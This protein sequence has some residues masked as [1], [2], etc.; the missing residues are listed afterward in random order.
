M[1]KLKVSLIHFLLSLGTFSILTMIILYIW[2]PCPYFSAAGGW[3]G[4]KIVS[5]VDVVLGP[6]LTFILYSNNKPKKELITDLSIVILLQLSAMA[7]GVNTIYMQRPVAIVYWEKNFITV[8]ASV[9]VQQNLDID[10]L[11]KF[12]KSLPVLIYAQKPTK[13]E[14]LQKMLDLMNEN[15][16][17]PHHQFT[18]YRPLDE[19]FQNMKAEQL[20]ID[21]VISNN[22][23]I[24]AQLVNKLAEKGMTIDN[25]LYFPLRSK[26]KN[27]ILMINH[28]GNIEDFILVDM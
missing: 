25:I 24:K 20:D 6:L 12:G 16:V 14:D 23:H 5:A 17:P 3:Q 26:Y 10:D 15:G 28:E 4:L 1:S 8:P 13:L 22:R 21:K 11:S 18:L 27:I 19:F 2:F 7:W 9:L